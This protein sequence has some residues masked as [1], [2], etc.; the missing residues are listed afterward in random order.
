[1][2]EYTDWGT[3][4]ARHIES[5]AYTRALETGRRLLSLPDDFP[6]SAV[7]SALMTEVASATVFG[8]INTASNQGAGVGIFIGKVGVDLQFK[9]LV[10]G[11]GVT[12]TPSG[13]EIEIAASV[14]GSG[15]TNTAS[16]LG[17]GADAFKSKVG[18][19]L[20]FRSFTAGVGIAIT[21]NADD[22]E[23][24]CTVVGAVA[25]G[26]DTELQYNDAGAF[27]GAAGLKYDKV[28]GFL[29]IGGSAPG[30]LLDV[31]KSVAGDKVVN[32]RNTSATGYGA[33]IS[34]NDNTKY[35]LKVA[36]AADTGYFQLFGKQLMSLGQEASALLTN[37]RDPTYAGTAFIIVADSARNGGDNDASIYLVS[38]IT[39]PDY[40]AEM[41]HQ[42][43]GGGDYGLRL[44]YNLLRDKDGFHHS[45]STVCGIQQSFE[46]DGAVSWEYAYPPV[47]GAASTYD[48]LPGKSLKI[49][50]GGFD[51]APGDY[52]NEYVLI[53]VGEPTRGLEIGVE[54]GGA[55]S[56]YAPRFRIRPTSV[57]AVNPLDVWVDGGW[58]NMQID[59]SGFLKGV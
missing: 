10:A 50:P 56:N 1:M 14:G 48:A 13:T 34:T 2:P 29:G 32:I 44:H 41:A 49:F 39:M 4:P 35:G 12:L 55:G 19:D 15:E 59:G 23:I 30:F 33:K 16:N 26:S 42:I 18:V 6:E 31:Q 52:K 9:S 47:L 46:V 36:D 43:L 53:T 22:I 40:P 57:D 25:A 11:S 20:Q 38:G 27:A 45:V 5:I 21:Q 7:L 24:A 54:T 3:L 51:G 8:E 17:A 28:T 37:L 58:K